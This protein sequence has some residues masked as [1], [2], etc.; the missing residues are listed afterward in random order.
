M[1]ANTCIT[2]CAAFTC[3]NLLCATALLLAEL[4][5]EMVAAENLPSHACSAA[6]LNPRVDG[7]QA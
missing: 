1:K 5:L 4:L 2:Q 6:E 3:F 7:S